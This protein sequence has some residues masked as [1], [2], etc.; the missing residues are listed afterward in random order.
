LLISKIRYLLTSPLGHRYV[1]LE[2]A[3]SR[4]VVHHVL[5]NDVQKVHLVNWA[6]PYVQRYMYKM[7]PLKYVSFKELEKDKLSQL[8]VV[9]T[10]ML[11]YKY[12]LNGLNITS[13]DLFEAS[14]ILKVFLLTCSFFI[15][16]IVVNHGPY[17][18]Y[19][20]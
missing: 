11:H 18:C 15:T 7:H 19:N 8:K 13:Q 6:L 16:I 4:E 9:M 1:F 2:Q 5:V 14:A 17:F 12:C 3:V 20:Y 10:E